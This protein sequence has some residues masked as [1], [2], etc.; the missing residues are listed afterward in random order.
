MFGRFSKEVETGLEDVVSRNTQAGTNLANHVTS[1]LER[2]LM[3]FPE[4]Q[5]ADIQTLFNR[6]LNYLAV[7]SG[8]N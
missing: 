8:D 5:H 7:H 3:E 4:N 1:E 6:I 2:R